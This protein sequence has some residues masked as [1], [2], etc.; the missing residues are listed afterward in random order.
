MGRRS[1]AATPA[2][3]FWSH[4]DRSEDGCW[5]WLGHVDPRGYGRAGSSWAHRLAY[6]FE[7]GT[8]PEGLE[9][10]HLCRNRGCVRPSHLEPVTH[11]ENLD[12]AWAVRRQ[13]LAT[14]CRNGHELATVGVYERRGV[15]ECM[16]CAR[17]SR[18]K[19]ER[20]RREASA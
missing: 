17:I 6:E 15:K 9:L 8:I 3:R 13:T 19:Y 20:R 1:N 14:H 16:E 2:E 4:V 5:L 10:D 12:R 18:R 7:V 11:A